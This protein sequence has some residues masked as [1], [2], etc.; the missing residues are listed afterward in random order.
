[1]T[2]TQRHESFFAHL[3]RGQCLRT[4]CEREDKK[5]SE[6]HGILLIE[7]DGFSVLLQNEPEAEM[8]PL[9]PGVGSG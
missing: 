3:E 2:F 8:L 1:M 6:R 5:F 4:V 9:V 7:L